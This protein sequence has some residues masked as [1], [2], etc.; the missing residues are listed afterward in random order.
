[1]NKKFLE[2]LETLS[3]EHNREVHKQFIKAMINKQNREKFND[4]RQFKPHAD[5]LY[6]QLINKIKDETE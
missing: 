4:I 6:K 3:K 5:S 2:I 1:M